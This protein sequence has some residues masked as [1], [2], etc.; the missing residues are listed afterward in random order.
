M[1]ETRPRA[2]SILL[3]SFANSSALDTLPA[4]IAPATKAQAKKVALSARAASPVEDSLA[5]LVLLEF[6]KRRAAAWEAK[7]ELTSAEA[8]VVVP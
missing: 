3:V 6:P 5:A 8:R 4:Y 2:G 1:R 7:C